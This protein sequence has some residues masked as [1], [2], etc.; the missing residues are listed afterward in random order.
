[1]RSVSR[2]S[3]FFSANHAPGPISAAPTRTAS[4]IKL[5]SGGRHAAARTSSRRGRGAVGEADGAALGKRDGAEVRQAPHVFVSGLARAGTTILMR[6]IHASGEFRSLTYRDMPF[7]LAPNLWGRVSAMS[8]TEAKAAERA[9]GD[10]IAVDVDSPESFDE[11]F[12]RVFDGE[13]YIARDHLAPHAPDDETRDRFA[14]YVTAILASGDGATRYLSK[15]NNNVLRLGA[16]RAT[17]PRAALLVPFRDPAAQARSLMRQHANFFDQQS[18]DGF[19]RAYMG[20]LGHHEFGGDHRPF[21][22]DAAGAARLAAGDPKGDAYWLEL[23]TQVYGW[24]ERS[25]PEDAIFVCYE[26]LCADPQVWAALGT[27][28]AAEL[29][30]LPED[31][32]RLDD[33]PVGGLTVTGAYTGTGMREGD[34]PKPVGVFLRDGDVASREFGRM[35]GLLIVAP[36]GSARIALASAA[37]LEGRRHDLTDLDGRRAFLEAASESGASVLQSHLLIRDGAL[38][39]RPV[40]DAPLAVRRVRSERSP[41]S[42]TRSR[43]FSATRCRAGTRPVTN[44]A[45]PTSSGSSPASSARPS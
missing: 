37:E 34:R 1:M 18:D 39:L 36:D 16:L 21:R 3:Y 4:T 24:L 7:V 5:Q 30:L 29:L 8:K 12:W 27:P 10:N 31:A 35:D 26:D 40:E 28:G 6:R 41:P 15:N 20:W 23:W 25:A 42:S 19:T 14:D 13:S 33:A 2:A 44:T 45:S 38:D 32:A 22:F 43:A 17:F 9:H 11:A